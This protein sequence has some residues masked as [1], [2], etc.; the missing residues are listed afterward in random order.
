[1]KMV[2]LIF[3]ILVL[4]FTFNIVADF[5][6]ETISKNNGSGW[7][8]MAQDIF[9][10]T[11]YYL[12]QYQVA[13]EAY[14][15]QMKLFPN[16]EDNAKALYRIAVSSQRLSDYPVALKYFKR[17][18]SEYPKSGKADKVKGRIADIEEVYLEFSR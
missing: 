12:R 14:S 10:D 3:L 7:A 18:L 4:L 6:Q 9:A 2:T 5:T 16:D 15:M 1:M 8:P 11:S 13:R 17:L